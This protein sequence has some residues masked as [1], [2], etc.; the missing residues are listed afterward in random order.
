MWR[1]NAGTVSVVSKFGLLVGLSSLASFEATADTVNFFADA[2]YSERV[3]SGSPHSSYKGTGVTLLTGRQV[4]I[5]ASGTGC[6]GASGP[7]FGPNGQGIPPPFTNALAP[8]LSTASLVGTMGGGDV[9]IGASYLG[10]GSGLLKLGFNDSRSD[11]NS[12]G[13]SAVIKYCQAGF[14][15]D[16]ATQT[17][18]SEKNSGPAECVMTPNPVHLGTGNKYQAESVYKGAGPNPLA[19]TLHYNRIGTAPLGRFGYKWQGSY[20]RPMDLVPQA[21]PTTVGMRRPTGRYILFTLQSGVWTGEADGRD[22]LVA[23]TSAGQITGWQL[24]TRDDELETYTADGRLTSIRARNGL[25]QSLTYDANGRLYRVTDHAGRYLQFAYDSLNR[26]TS[27]IDPAGQPIAFGYDAKSN[28]TSITHQDQSV[29]QFHY[30]DTRFP[31]ALTGITDERQIRYATYEYDAQARV[32][33]SVHAGADETNVAYNPNGA[34]TVTDA[35]GTART[36]ALATSVGVIK[37]ASLTE[38]CP[39]G[40]GNTNNITYDAN[41]NRNVVTDFNGNVTDHDYDL[42]R[43][44]ETSRTEAFNTLQQRT[45]TTQWHPNYRLPTQIDEPGRSTVFTYDGN[46]NRLTQTVTDTALSLSRTTTWTYTTAGLLDTVDGPRT[47]VSDVT[48]YDYDTATNLSAITNALGQVTQIPEYDA[49]GNPKK[50]IDPNGVVTLLTYDLRQRLRTRTVAGV[51]TSFDYDDV[52]QLKK[53]T[54]PDNS[55]LEYTY[56]NARRLTDIEDSQGNRIHYTLDALGNRT[57]EE[58]FDPADNLRRRQSQVFNALNRLEQIKNASNEVVVA[59]AYDDQGNR[60]TETQAGAFETGSAYDALNRLHGVTDAKLGVTQYGFNQLDQ[61]ESVTDPKGLTTSYTLNALGDLTEQDSPD[62]GA[63]AYTYDSAGNLKTRTDERGITATYSYDALNRLTLTDYPGTAEDVTYTYD[64]TNYSGTIANGI[65]RLTG[66]VD[67]SGTTTLLYSARG[68]LTEERRVIAGT[69]YVTGYDYDS[70]DRLIGVSYPTGR[71]VSYIRDAQGRIDE[72]RTTVGPTTTTLAQDIEYMPFGGIKS[73]ALGN[74]IVVTRA[75]DLD[76]RL[77]GIKSQGSATVQDLKLH[78]DIRSNVWKVEDFV[79][80]GRLQ[81]F[82]YDELSRMVLAQGAYGLQEFT[83]DEVGNRMTHDS[84]PPGGAL[85]TDT[86][87]YP[88]TSHRLSS[89]SGGASFG[90]D[91]IGNVEDKGGLTL[92]YNAA[93][94]QANATLGSASVGSTYAASGQRI[95]KTS[96]GETTVFHYGPGGHLLA[97]TGSGGLLIQREYVWLEDIPLAVENTVYRPEV[98]VDNTDGAFSASA[99]WSSSTGSSGY[100][101]SDYA[102]HG[103]AGEPSGTAVMDDIDAVVDQTVTGVWLP[104][105]AV[106]A[107]SYGALYFRSEGLVAGAFSWNIPVLVPGRFRVYARW[108]ADPAFASDAQY[109]ITHGAGISTVSVDQRSS[110]GSWNLLGTFDFGTHALI[111]L[112]AQGSG[113]VIADAVRIVPAGAIDPATWSA[114]EA[115]SYEVYARWPASLLHSR[116]ATFEVTDSG[117]TTELLRDQQAGG[118]WSLLGSFSFAS[119]AQGVRLSADPDSMVAA[120]AARFVPAGASVSTTTFAYFHPD[121]LGT[122]QM[123]TDQNQ[124]V[125]W[126]A[127]Y[128]PFGQAT[129]T[130]QP[131]FENPLRFPGQ[132]FDEET[133]LHQNWHRDYDPSLARYLQSDPIGLRGGLNTYGYAFANPLTYVDRDGREAAT[134]ADQ[135]TCAANPLDCLEVAECKRKALAATIARFGRQGANDR[136]DAF[137][138][139]YWSCCMAQKIGGPEAKK[140]GDAHEEFAK[141]KKC[142]KN[143]DLSNNATGRNLGAAN[144]SGDC[145]TLCNNAPLVNAPSGDCSPCGSY[146]KY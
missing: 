101:G 56:D 20:D 122:P 8:S 74:G 15:Y 88:G 5:T 21:N 97:E 81:T 11:D 17:C 76:Y 114:P 29:R 18:I 61:L 139:C 68:N 60:T 134:T 140:F 137:R 2:T 107:G 28:L 31:D 78:Y 67:E 58:V 77:E 4:A 110:G 54:L 104:L 75:H 72:V 142:E 126:D 32:I 42:T 79:N 116:W 144:L 52:G 135:L 71:S 39:T 91:A 44:L 141:N 63:T 69:T 111:S 123:L 50:I 99:G 112:N 95:V 117:G 87:S 128:E 45:I 80:T 38:P 92:S 106:P 47:D 27:I 26:V 96:G 86:Y 33:R 83:Y 36:Y 108:V 132:Y 119:T 22:R 102:A 9:F 90:Y 16:P 109:S 6:V 46:G 65:G 113:A 24:T 37:V 48:D 35:L 1:A 57:K 40:C 23:L 13:F 62:S 145:G 138:H 7:C 129:I 100:L 121:H 66:I 136:S 125:V 10:V 118:A 115:Q 25:V 93:N 41:G 51:T 94:R 89:I 146:E 103:P 59:F 53:V 30:E 14:A 133:G 127:V 34:S 143:M 19:L 43:N 98:I 85:T 105:T 130:K 12:G 120:D 64:G 84:T 55:F 73:Y 49:H 131:Y 124:V 70:A 82:E 3:V